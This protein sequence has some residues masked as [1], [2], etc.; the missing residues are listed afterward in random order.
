MVEGEGGGGGGGGGV[1]TLQYSQAELAVQF[2]NAPLSN[3]QLGMCIGRGSCSN[4]VRKGTAQK[5]ARSFLCLVLVSRLGWLSLHTRHQQLPAWPAYAGRR[6]CGDKI[7]G[8]TARSD[9]K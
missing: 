2:K 1:T 9:N 7:N 5:V 8:W 4:M 6:G 3:R